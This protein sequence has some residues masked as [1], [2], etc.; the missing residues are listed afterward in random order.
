LGEDG[1]VICKNVGAAVPGR[2]CITHSRYNSYKAVY[3]E[4]KKVEN[5]Y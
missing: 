2:P 5:E 4:A 1:C 3:A